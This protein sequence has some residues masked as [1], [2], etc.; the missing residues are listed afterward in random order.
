MIDRLKDIADR[1][2]GTRNQPMPAEFSGIT[3]SNRCIDSVDL[4]TKE[5]NG[6]NKAIRKA[7]YDIFTTKE[8]AEHTPNGGGD[9]PPMDAARMQAVKGDLSFTHRCL[10]F[11]LVNCKH[12]VFKVGID[13]PW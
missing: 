2:E 10:E 13:S 11:V 9:K 3:F 12:L 8:L 4:L 1:M 6:L 5:A 7:I